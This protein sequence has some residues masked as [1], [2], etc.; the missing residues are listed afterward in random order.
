MDMNNLDKQFHLAQ[1]RLNSGPASAQKAVVPLFTIEF[2]GENP[3]DNDERILKYMAKRKKALTCFASD[4][5][6]VAA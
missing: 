2:T 4:A 3:L 5:R 1:S 6:R